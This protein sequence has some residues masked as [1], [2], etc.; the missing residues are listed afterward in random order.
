VT[1]AKALTHAYVLASAGSGKTWQL[2]SRYLRLIAAGAEPAGI[3]ASTFT[4][5]AAGEIR[6]RILRRLAEAATDDEKLKELAGALERPDL[7][8]DQALD[9]LAVV[10]VRLHQVQIRT[11]DS[12]FASVVS[13]FA[14]EL[15]LPYAAKIVDEDES[16]QMRSDAIR[17]TLESGGPRAMIELLRQL[18][19]DAAGRAVTETIDK[20]VHGLMALHQEAPAGAWECVPRPKGR[21]GDDAL[22]DAVRTL[23]EFPVPAGNKRLHGAWLRS[24]DAARAGDW[25]SFIG[26]GLPKAIQHK[27]SLYYGKPLDPDIVA[28]YRPLVRHARA[29]LVGRARDQTLATRDLLQRFEQHLEAISVCRGPPPAVASTRSSSASTR[30]CGI[31][32][33][34]SS[35]T[36]ACPSGGPWNPWPGRS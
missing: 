7:T 22:A 34:T 31:C 36:R 16:A 8:R 23:E 33:S 4:R 12:F 19:E 20:T 29:V 25:D 18:T 28:V 32:C 17:A 9:L 14:P 1:A 15:G 24:L 2:S 3:L 10:A 6:D 11:L 5:A 30:R 21:L 27:D 26:N 35:R 13:A